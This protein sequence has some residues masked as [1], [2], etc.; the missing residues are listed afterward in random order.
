MTKDQQIALQLSGILMFNCGRCQH[1]WL[2]RTLKIPAQCPAC[3]SRF[4]NKPREREIAKARKA[5]KRDTPQK[6]RT[7]SRVRAQAANGDRGDRGRRARVRAHPRHTKSASP[8][9]GKGENA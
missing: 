2:R 4:W 6:A 9:G 3:K 5:G 1:S 7:T 8:R